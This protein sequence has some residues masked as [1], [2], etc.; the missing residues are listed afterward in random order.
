MDS[1]TFQ[2]FVLAMPLLPPP[3]REALA[4]ASDR[5][6]EVDRE[7]IATLLRDGLAAHAHILEEGIAQMEQLLKKGEKVVRAS[8]E[9]DER[10]AEQL[11]DFS[12]AA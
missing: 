7:A 3:V 12:S 8:R 6:K 5:L 11:P 1:A 2:A 9:Q 10:S 4:A